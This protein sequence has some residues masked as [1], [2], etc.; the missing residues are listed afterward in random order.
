MQGRWN[1]SPWHTHST[2]QR[3]YKPDC[4]RQS[5]DQMQ[6]SKDPT[7]GLLGDERTTMPRYFPREVAEVALAHKVGDAALR[8]VSLAVQR[9]RAEMAFYE[10]DTL[11][12]FMSKKMPDRDCAVFDMC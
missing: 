11:A 6:R 10:T 4:S 5:I 12:C 9:Q 3:A 2:I 7:A 1:F 8:A